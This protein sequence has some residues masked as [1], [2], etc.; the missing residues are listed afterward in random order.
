MID[1]IIMAVL[2]GLLTTIDL[3]LLYG[4]RSVVIQIFEVVL[5]IIA[6]VFLVITIMAFFY[7]VIHDSIYDPFVKFFARLSFVSVIT[8]LTLAVVIM[9]ITMFQSSDKNQLFTFNVLGRWIWSII[10]LSLLISWTLKLIE[11]VE[12]KIPEEQKI[13]LVDQDLEDPRQ[14]EAASKIS[15]LPAPEIEPIEP[16]E[17]NGNQFTKSQQDPNQLR[18]KSVLAGPQSRNQ[19]ILKTSINPVP[20]TIAAEENLIVET[21]DS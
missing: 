2:G 6:I 12:H 21:K 3:D 8:C 11:L 20:E 17:F 1:F 9:L 14:A 5:M 4:K 18:N 16:R 19:S 13:E 7:Y 10:F 15:Q